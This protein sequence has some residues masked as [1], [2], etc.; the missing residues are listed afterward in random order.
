MKG[1]GGGEEH[2]IFLPSPLLCAHLKVCLSSSLLSL[3]LMKN[4][5]LTLSHGED[6]ACGT[7]TLKAV[8]RGQC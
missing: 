7:N 5:M 8:I 6:Q 2:S 4:M 3:S 1:R